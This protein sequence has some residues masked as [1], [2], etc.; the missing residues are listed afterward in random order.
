MAAAM[1]LLTDMHLQLWCT[2]L[3]VAVYEPFMSYR[4][5]NV[6]PEK[7]KWRR[8]AGNHSER[9]DQTVLHSVCTSCI[10][11]LWMRIPA[12]DV[13]IKGIEVKQAKCV[14]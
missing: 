6:M 4:T 10:K 1:L 12:V 7:A 14:M 11:H 5:G 9:R 2:Q 8:F 13:R 3:N